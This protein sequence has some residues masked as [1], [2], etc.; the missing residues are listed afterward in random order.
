MPDYMRGYADRATASAAEPGSPIR[1]IASTEGIG[2]DGLIIDQSGWDLDAFKSNP[3]ILWSHDYMGSR[4]P[5]GRADNVWVEDNKLMVDIAFD[6]QDDFAR[7]IE[8]KYR[9][10]ILSAVSVGWNS[11]EIEPAKNPNVAGI[12]RKAQLLD[13]SA[14]AIP[15][16]PG[17]LMERQKRALADFGRELLKVIEPATTTTSNTSTTL[18]VT[19]TS[20][21]PAARATWE[22]TASAM[23]RFLSPFAQR[24]DGTDREAEYRRL[25][26]EYARHKKTPP[27]L[28]GQD[29]LDAMGPEEVKGL[30][31][32]N[33]PGLF[34]DLFAAIET[35][36]GAVLSTRNRDDLGRAIELIQ[37]VLARAKKEPAEE[38]TDDERAMDF[39]QSLADGIATGAAA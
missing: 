25:A 13:I 19:Q 20:D 39:L 27:E 7:Q 32:E 17:A 33:E 28:I 21:E 31:L 23:V 26:R 6:Q 29:A 2:R 9:R 30:F 35:R 15:G 37:G 18:T 38:P 8:S 4:P 12:V 24:P 14:V 10:G 36:A 22:D 16:D 5:I 11:V 1:F 34:P 3:S